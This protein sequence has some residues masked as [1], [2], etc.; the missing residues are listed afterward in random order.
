MNTSNHIKLQIQFA[1]FIFLLRI[2]RPMICEES[3]PKEM[4]QGFPHERLNQQDWLEKLKEVKIKY[5][6]EDDM[7]T[8]SNPDT[9][10]FY[11]LKI[12]KSL[13]KMDYLKYMSSLKNFLSE[14]YPDLLKWID[15]PISCYYSIKGNIGQHH[16]YDFIVE[17]DLMEG[18]LY[19]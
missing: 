19:D 5:P 11:I 8:T 15:F 18:D 7:E 14:N 17:S 9:K 3:E 2:Y 13:S 10:K 16:I 4:T 1:L 6:T 12:N